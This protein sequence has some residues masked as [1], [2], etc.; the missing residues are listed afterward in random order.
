MKIIGRL[1]K[2]IRFLQSLFG[3]CPHDAAGWPRYVVRYADAD[4][5]DDGFV[6]HCYQCG[7]DIPAT[8]EFAHRVIVTRGR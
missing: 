3:Y 7:R 5:I 4:R 6:R 8:V 1:K 2:L